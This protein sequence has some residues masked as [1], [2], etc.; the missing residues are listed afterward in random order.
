MTSAKSK[1]SESGT[2]KNDTAGTS[3]ASHD[4]PPAYDG[5]STSEPPPTYESVGRALTALSQGDPDELILVPFVT[6][7]VGFSIHNYNPFSHKQGEIRQSIVTRRMKRSHYLAHYVK[8]MN[9]NFVGTSTPAVD[10]ALV[11]VPG[12]SSPEDSLRQVNEVAFK[13]QRLRG[14]GIGDW[15][16]PLQDH[17]AGYGG[18]GMAM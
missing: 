12:K 9:G 4:T 5:S 16:K 8:D 13:V 17:P 7:T 18:G 1:A 6:R 11:F 10:A 3:T 14:D 15:G 2:S